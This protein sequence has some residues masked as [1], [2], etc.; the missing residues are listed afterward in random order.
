MLRSILLALALSQVNVVDAAECTDAEWQTS[1]S[2]WS[3][4]ATTSACAQYAVGT[5]FV[6]APCSALPCVAVMEQVGEE[7]PD[8]TVS[9]VNNKIEVQNAM[10]RD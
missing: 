5:S 2:I 7:L 1:Q 10:T 9:G 4:A 6:S 8:C 3:W